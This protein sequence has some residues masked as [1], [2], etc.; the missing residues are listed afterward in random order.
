MLITVSVLCLGFPPAMAT[1]S[2]HINPVAG[3]CIKSSTI[4]SSVYASQTL[5][6]GHKVFI[7]IAWDSNVP[8]PPAGSEE[9][10]QRAMKGED[11]DRFNPDGWYVPV[12]VSQG[13]QD[14]DKGSFILRFGPLHS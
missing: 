8:A 9:V 4:Q 7:N 11:V 13:R 2:I 12:I 10:I 5:P 14:K 6:I 3:F 1:A